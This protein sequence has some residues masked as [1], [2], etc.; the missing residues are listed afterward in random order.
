MFDQFS[1]GYLGFT[2]GPD[3]HTIYYLTGGPIYEANKRVTGKATTAKGEAR[4]LE[5]L[6]LVSYDIPNRKYTDHGVVLYEKGDRPT[7]VNSIAVGRDG[8][9]YTLARITDGGQTR[10]DLVAI[11]SPFKPR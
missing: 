9:V 10:A 8:T 6:H 3:G 7:Y 5:D 11:P 1:Y 2:L 4:G